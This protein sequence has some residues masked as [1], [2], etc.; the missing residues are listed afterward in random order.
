MQALFYA[1]GNMAVTGEW[2]PDVF[3]PMNEVINGLIYC[4]RVIEPAGIT[5]ELHMGLF[6]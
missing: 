5:K 4:Y 3:Y 2:D 6:G 1:A